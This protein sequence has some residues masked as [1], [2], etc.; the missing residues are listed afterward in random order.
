MANVKSG[1]VCQLFL[2]LLVLTSVE[3]DIKD[4]MRNS[5]SFKLTELIRKLFPVDEKADQAVLQNIVPN[6]INGIKN[7]IYPPSTT[8]APTTTVQTD[9]TQTTDQPPETGDPGE[10]QTTSTSIASTSDDDKHATNE[11]QTVTTVDRAT[12]TPESI[13]IASPT[14]QSDAAETT[15]SE[16]QTSTAP[17]T[18]ES[19]TTPTEEGDS[20]S[21]VSDEPETTETPQDEAAETTES[22]VQ[23]ST[24][25]G[26]DES[27]TTPTE[28]GDSDSTVSDEPET[29][30]TPQDE[31]A[32]TTES[33]VQ[34]STAP[35]TDESSTTPTEEGD[36]DSTVSD[37]P[38]TTETPQD[39]A[40]ETTES[41][42][43]TSTAPGTDESSTTPTEEGDS[44]STVSD[45]PETTETPQDE[46]AETTESEV[47]TSTM[48]TP[49]EEEITD[50][51]TSTLSTTTL[52]PIEECTDYAPPPPAL[53]KLYEKLKP[54]LNA[55]S[56]ATPTDRRKY[57]SYRKLIKDITKISVSSSSF[58]Q[59]VKTV[60]TS[61]QSSI[62]ESVDLQR[63]Y[64]EATRVN[65][66]FQLKN[67]VQDLFNKFTDLVSRSLLNSGVCNAQS[68]AC[69]DKLN[70]ELPRFMDDMNQEI[71]TCDVIFNANIENPQGTLV[72]TTTVDRIGKEYDNIQAKCLTTGQSNDKT[73]ACLMKNLP[74]YV[75]RSAAYF[76]S[77]ENA[78][79]QGTNLMG[80][81]TKMA[82]SCYDNAYST[83][84][85]LFN[86]G[87][88]KLNAC[89]QG[90][91]SS[92]V[93]LHQ[94]LDK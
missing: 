40:A 25:P 32:E 41:E 29:T 54:H 31:A 91:T 11:D 28:E 24:A 19:S 67:H 2:I 39:E 9:S 73:L 87:M 68:Q 81:V 42:I 80:Y 46:A 89:V 5:V 13:T 4:K 35:G 8:S 1:F 88:T 59:K 16:V 26:T 65:M 36:S 86:N 90:E 71:V 82:E 38:E 94:E 76:S 20:D 10:Q 52:E 57:P 15:E 56:R 69:W 63:K 44:D 62:D 79:N 34:T 72:R 92:D 55:S 74:Y 93:R 7:F 49:P 43:Q 70:S 50:E 17:G 61:F 53:R 18:D 21:T 12:S 85:Q 3:A 58:S 14:G 60:I 75:P 47:H 48:P 78:V 83:R 22:E 51:V 84:T 6:I 27:S 30:E 23:T 37:E 64:Y 77:L 66:L 45:E 33:E